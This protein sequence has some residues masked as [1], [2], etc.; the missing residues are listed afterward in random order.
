MKTYSTFIEEHDTLNEMANIS[1][2]SY[3]SLDMKAGGFTNCVMLY[4]RNSRIPSFVFFV[5]EEVT[6]KALAFDIQAEKLYKDAFGNRLVMDEFARARAIDLNRRKSGDSVYYTLTDDDSLKGYIKKVPKIR[7]TEDLIKW[8]KTKTKLTKKAMKEI[9]NLDIEDVNA[10]IQEESV[11]IYGGAKCL[12]PQD[13]RPS[14]KNKFEVI[15]EQAAKIL[16]KHGLSD[17]IRKTEVRFV[18]ISGNANGLYFIREKHLSID[19]KGLRKPDN[20]M[21]TIVHEL[22]H[23]HMYEFLPA[24]TVSDIS[25][26][27][28][29]S[30]RTLDPQGRAKAEAQNLK[31]VFKI[32]DKVKYN[33]KRPAILK[34]GRDLKIIKVNYDKMTLVSNDVYKMGTVGPATLDQFLNCDF[35][36]EKLDKVEEYL[37]KNL[38]FTV[39]TKKSSAKVEGIWPSKYAKKNHSE[40]YAEMFTL[41]MKDEAGEMIKGIMDSIVKNKKFPQELV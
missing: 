11:E 2:K 22:G 32:G 12:Y 26:F 38:P 40:Y 13:M 33:G 24:S 1:V 27:Y 16:Q 6:G 21:W 30:M 34:L 29:N 37:N 7:K 20:L 17:V 8:A 14:Y 4:G 36:F 39:S 15:W 28:A 5:D 18:D 10:V 9:F 41:Y 31:S 3:F 19:R 35:E 25:K 23:K